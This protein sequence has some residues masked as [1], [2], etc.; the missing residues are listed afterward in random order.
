MVTITTSL[1][2]AASALQR[3]ALVVYPTETAYALGADALNP[4]AVQAVFA[5]KGRVSSKALPVIVA[6]RAMAER[7]AEF[8]PLARVLASVYWPG[9]LTLVL[10]A[11]PAF[12]SELTGP[13]GTIALRVSSHPTACELSQ[14]LN[15][16]LISTS[17]NASGQPTSYNVRRVRHDFQGRPEHI[18]LIDGG[19]LRRCRPSTI[20]DC[21]K[22]RPVVLRQG[23]LRPKLL[24]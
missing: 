8:S 17:A 23:A 6:S 2:T 9:P 19:T 21:T 10:P 16:P 14:R 12:P 18:L 5:A 7:Y 24:Y 11:T 1:A 20:V 3:G 22:D 13:G 15:R 4:N